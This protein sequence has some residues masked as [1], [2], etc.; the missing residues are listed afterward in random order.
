MTC[1]DLGWGPPVFTARCWWGCL[2]SPPVILPSIE[3]LDCIG[4]G[5]VN[6]DIKSGVFPDKVSIDG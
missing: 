3:G 4:G 6:G 5:D 2:R 1:V